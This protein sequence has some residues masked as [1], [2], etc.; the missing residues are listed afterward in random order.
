[1]PLCGAVLETRSSCAW[2][3]RLVEEKKMS[4]AVVQQSFIVRMDCTRLFRCKMEHDPKPSQN[5]SAFR[6]AAS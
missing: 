5:R 1:M 6:N 3:V 2:A 4:E